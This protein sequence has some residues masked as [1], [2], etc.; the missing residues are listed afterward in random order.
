MK[1]LV[2]VA[3]AK[4]LRQVLTQPDTF[5]KGPDYSVR[6][7]LAIGNGLVTSIGHDH[8]RQRA[9]LARVDMLIPYMINRNEGLFEQI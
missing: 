6:F 3:D 4:A 9:V 8:K 7:K 2:F 1:P 5:T